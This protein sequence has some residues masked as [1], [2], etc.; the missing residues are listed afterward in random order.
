MKLNMLLESSSIDEV[1]SQPFFSD[2]AKSRFYHARLPFEG[3]RS[4]DFRLRDAPRDSIRFIHNAINQES[5]RKFGV[6]VRSL[7]FTFPSLDQSQP[8]FEDYGMPALVVPKG[9]NYRIFLHPEYT[10]FTVQG[11]ADSAR[12]GDNLVR[13]TWESIQT[14]DLI[15]EIFGDHVEVD[16][17][18]AVEII[19]SLV[20]DTLSSDMP[21]INASFNNSRHSVVDVV[22]M[23]LLLFAERFD[24]TFKEYNFKDFESVVFDAFM[25]QLEN[26]IGYVAR[27]Y[28]EGLIEAT[29]DSEVVSANSEVPEVMM[30]MP[31]G[32]Y[33]VAIDV[34]KGM[35]HE[36]S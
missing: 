29:D 21:R 28:V 32:F 6:P 7:L 16:G 36:A 13:R 3:I 12:I 25:R 4:L 1:F 14:L 31:D 8:H 33:L 26:E 23:A 10:D 9:E 24:K 2:F 18:D 30:Y 15:N 17:L 34:L 35:S 27:D 20:D 22:E 11:Q 5:E 19:E